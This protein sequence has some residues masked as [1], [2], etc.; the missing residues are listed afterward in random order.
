MNFENT[1]DLNEV[2]RSRSF[3]EDVYEALKTVDMAGGVLNA[4]KT[5][6]ISKTLPDIAKNEKNKERSSSYRNKGNTF[7][8]NRQFQLAFKCYNKALLYAPKNSLE[9]VQAYSN[10]SALYLQLKAYT[11]SLKDIETCLK[12]NCTEELQIKLAKRELQCQTMLRHDIVKRNIFKNFFSDKFFNFKSERHPDIPCLSSDVHVDY[13]RGETKMV[14]VRDVAVGTVLA[15]ETAFATFSFDDKAYTACYYCQ[16]SALNL[17]PCDNCCYALFCSEKCEKL[18]LNEYHN[19]EC[20]IMN[21]LNSVNVGNKFRL[22]MKTVLKLKSRYIQW[23]VLIEECRN[24]GANR[25]KTGS[26]SEIYDVEKNSSMLSFNGKQHF[27]HGVLYNSCFSVAT[28]IHYLEKLTGFFPA[29]PEECLEAQKCFAKL[30]ISLEL[31]WP[32]NTEIE[33]AAE[34]LPG[35]DLTI[36]FPSHYGWFALASKVRHVCEPNVV[37]IGLDN[38]VALVAIEPIKKD[39]E[40]KISHMYVYILVNTYYL[41]SKLLQEYAS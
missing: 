39:T 37:V 10:R 27:I 34:R 18:C 32:S 24:I 23:N 29:E 35:S 14:T 6:R 36:S 4:L 25:M 2:L 40:L 33:N 7:Y 19:I 11:A 1:I 21:V 15:I 17:Y 20:K 12:L 22:A 30:F 9:L 31:L 8:I 3:L 26:L 38:R 41:I 16:K 5:L 28:I 13:E